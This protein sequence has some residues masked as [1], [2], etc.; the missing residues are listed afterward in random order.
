[1]RV[2]RNILLATVL[3]AASTAFA[4]WFIDNNAENK[5]NAIQKMATIQSE[6]GFSFSV[7]RLPS[8]DQVWARFSLPENSSDQL[9]KDK[10]P[11]IWIDANA[12]RHMST[13]KEFQE[14]LHVVGS[15]LVVYEWRPKQ[16]AVVIWHGIIEEGLNQD[17]ISLL[18]GDEIKVRYFLSSGEVKDV[19]FTLKG[20][21]SSIAQAL[22]ISGSLEPR[23]FGSE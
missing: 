6:S 13:S 2:H 17:I 12:P 23:S 22:D 18:Q 8:D 21:A 5:I 19:I 14:S 9:D 4:Y 7:Y 3:L 20:K 1:M 11:I 16:I 15:D 10:S